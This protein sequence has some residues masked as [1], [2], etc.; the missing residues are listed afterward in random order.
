MPIL[1]S[2]GCAALLAHHTP[3]LAKDGWENT[4]D[5]YS[6]IGGAEIANIPRSILTLRP[7]SAKGLSVVN[8]S[9]RQTTGWKDDA[10][11][12]CTHYFVKRTDN[13]ERPA[14]IPVDH[15]LA[16]ELISESKQAGSGKQVSRKGSPEKVAEIVAASRSEVARQDL[17]ARAAALCECSPRTAQDAVKEAERIGLITP[18]EKP[19]GRGGKDAIFYRIGGDNQATMNQ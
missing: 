18:M 17:I 15:N 16:E 12:Y 7:T 14:W 19:T 6:G 13:P 11:N 5:T 10:G 3:K 8:V 9:K 1:Q 4:D 2:N